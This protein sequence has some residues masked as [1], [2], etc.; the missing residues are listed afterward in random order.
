MGNASPGFCAWSLSQKDRREEFCY[1]DANGPPSPYLDFDRESL[2]Q[3][4]IRVALS[5]STDRGAP[6]V[7][8]TCIS[9]RPSWSEFL[10]PG[11]LAKT[12]FRWIAIRLKLILIHFGTWTSK[13]EAHVTLTCNL[14]CAGF[15][16]AYCFQPHLRVCCSPR[17]LPVCRC[18]QRSA[19]HCS[20]AVETWPSENE[21]G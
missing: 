2:A 11:A 20:A 14:R 16:P 1:A 15:Q 19:V 4:M 12:Y 17:L 9:R 13:K 5:S 10:F 8:C 7:C 3:L 21:L 18:V 6:S